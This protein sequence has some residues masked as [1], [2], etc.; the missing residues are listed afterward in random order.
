MVPLS[1]RTPLAPNRRSVVLGAVLAGALAAASFGPVSGQDPGT[2]DGAVLDDRTFEPVEGASVYV[3]GQGEAQVTGEDGIFSFD[4]LDPGIVQ[5]RVQRE[6]YSSS[7]EEVEVLSGGGTFLQLGITPIDAI[8]DALLVQGRRPQADLDVVDQSDSDSGETA[9]DLLAQRL[10]GVTV[11]RPTGALGGGV[12]VRIR[13]VS[14]VTGSREPAI[15]LDGVRLNPSRAPGLPLRTTP[16]MQILDEI[17]A[18]QVRSIRVL[19]G[20]SASVIY[21]ESADGVIVIETDR[22]VDPDPREPASAPSDRGVTGFD[23]GRG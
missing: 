21:G 7:V 16:G 19:R 13:G 1:S 11:D 12:E 3:S 10:P 9:S 5:V 2:L 23:G 14:S 18:S 22:G 17:P 6:G 4:A 8:L 20:P 15:F